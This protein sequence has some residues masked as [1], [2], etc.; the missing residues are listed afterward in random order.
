MGFGNR[1]IKSAIAMF[2]EKVR[3]GDVPDEIIAFYQSMS[4]NDTKFWLHG[5]FTA[6]CKQKVLL[7]S[8]FF[9][10]LVKMMS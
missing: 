10:F 7:E 1:K 2:F 5:F 8:E 9:D 3:D 4:P 6:I